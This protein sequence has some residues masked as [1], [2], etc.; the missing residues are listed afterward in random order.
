MGVCASCRVALFWPCKRTHAYAHALFFAARKQL[1]KKP[2]ADLEEA[3]TQGQDLRAQLQTAEG[4]SKKWHQEMMRHALLIPNDSHPHAPVGDESTAEV[5]QLVGSKSAFTFEP[6]NHLELGLHHDLFDL[7]HSAAATGSKFATLKNE[8]VWWLSGGVA[9]VL[10]P[11]LCHPVCGFVP[12]ATS[13]APSRSS[14]W[15]RGPWGCCGARGSS[16]S[17]RQTLCTRRL[18]RRAGFTPVAPTPKST[19][20]STRT[21]ASLARQKSRWRPGACSRFSRSSSCRCG[22]LLFRTASAVKPA[23]AARKT[24]GCTACIS[25]AK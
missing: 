19:T 8:C 9:A 3:R 16:C 11:C 5:A 13:G 22:W 10:P 18:C 17:C 7:R 12:A 20:C 25:S 14:T 21:C 23:A 2:P 6:R 4:E 1:G 15:R 24:R